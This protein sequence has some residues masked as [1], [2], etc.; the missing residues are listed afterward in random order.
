M[1]EKVKTFALHWGSGIIEEEV[2]IE[3]AYH[4]PTIQLLKFTDG[5]AAGTYELRCCHYDL[6]GR[7]RKEREILLR[8]HLDAMQGV[9]PEERQRIANI[10]EELIERLLNEPNT[11]LRNGRGMRGRL[12]AIDALRHVFGLEKH[13]GSDEEKE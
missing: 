9:S 10:T 5:E 6:R 11:R 3:T 8:E 13:G 12:G 2:Q 7:F 4:R 1:S